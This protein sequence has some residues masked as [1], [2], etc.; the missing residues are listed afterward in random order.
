MTKKAKAKQQT[1]AKNKQT[2]KPT[3]CAK[4]RGRPPTTKKKTAAPPPFKVSPSHKVAADGNTTP[5][6]QSDAIAEIMSESD[7]LLRAA[8]D[9]QSLGRL[10]EAQS[11]LYL[12]HARLVGL[13]QLLEPTQ[14]ECNS[15]DSV[16]GE[17]DNG[18]GQEDASMTS[19][20]DSSTPSPSNTSLQLEAP[21]T[22]HE[23][24]SDSLAHSAKELLYQHSGKGM[25]YK[26][27]IERKR[28][29]RIGKNARDIERKVNKEEKQ[30]PSNNQKLNL[31]AHGEIT[32]KLSTGQTDEDRV[33][34]S[35]ISR[36]MLNCAHLDAHC[37]LGSGME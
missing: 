22:N 33:V 31:T 25:Q 16:D 26:S 4:R 36:T 19:C 13:G 8:H 12:A 9:A 3:K 20:D 1:K 37:L 24:I 35:V 28:W 17:N 34:P 14:L 2:K 15:L 21:L 27:D 32:S 23:N 5:I 18:A 29:N 30:D 11:Y 7:D 10:S 6:S